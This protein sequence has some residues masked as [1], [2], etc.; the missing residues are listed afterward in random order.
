MIGDMAEG[1]GYADSD[2]RVGERPVWALIALCA[3]LIGCSPPRAVLRT[4]TRPAPV[5]LCASRCG[6]TLELTYFGVGGFLV[7]SGAHALLTAP[8]FTHPDLLTI[9]FRLPVRSD[10]ALIA[11]RLALVDTALL[12]TVPALLVG[13][14]HYDHLLDVPVVARRW[15]PNA[16]I[17]GGPTVK[18]TLAGDQALDTARVRALADADVGD[19]FH[20]GRWVYPVGGRFRFMA[21]RSDHAPIVGGVRFAQGRYT[22]DLKRLPR[23]AVGYRLGEPYAYLIDVIAPDSTPLLRILYHDAAVGPERAALPPLEGRDR[24]DVD[25]FILTA[26]NFDAVPDYPTAHI[27]ALRPR[28]TVVAHWENFFRS[29][30]R[31]PRLIPF[32]RARALA[33]RL[34]RAAPGGWITPEPMGV[35][36]VAY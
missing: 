24:R 23:S 3:L 26:G 33:R 13:H 34:D 20:A 9:A 15:A 22:R 19:R 32:L 1:F 27:A 10:S 28:L 31:R 30:E 36:R 6:D 11:R 7:R 25:L 35:L 2:A 18:H 5:T 16:T 12:R 4:A 21:V 8:S 14:A 17:Y 29:P